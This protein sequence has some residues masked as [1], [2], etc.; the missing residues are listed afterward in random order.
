MMHEEERR[1]Q[2][3]RTSAVGARIQL[4]ALVLLEAAEVAGAGSPRPSNLVARILRVGRIGRRLAHGGGRATG[5]AKARE[6]GQGESGWLKD[7]R[8]SQSRWTARGFLHG[9]K[10]DGQQ[11]GDHMLVTGVVGAASSSGGGGGGMMLLFVSMG[12][13]VVMRLNEMGQGP[14]SETRSCPGAVALAVCHW[15]SVNSA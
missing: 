6:A 12:V 1:H 10:D 11:H 5:A 9:A 8:W 2:I 15:A 14:E 7:R 4:I 3:G 13:A